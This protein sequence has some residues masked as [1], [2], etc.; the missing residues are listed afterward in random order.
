MIVLTLEPGGT[1]RGVVRDPDGTP[2]AGAKVFVVPA[3]EPKFLANPRYVIGADGSMSWSSSDDG[4]MMGASSGSS[5]FTGTTK[6]AIR[7][8]TD[9]EGAYLVSGLRIPAAYRV[10][11]EGCGG[12]GAS[13]EVALSPET[14]VATAGV[15]LA[16]RAVL[17]VRLQAPDGRPATEDLGLSIVGAREHFLDPRGGRMHRVGFEEDGTGR[18][19]WLVAG[20]YEILV[21]MRDS[22]PQRKR[23]EV[24]A[25]GTTEVIVRGVAGQSLR[26]VV[27][28]GAGQPVGKAKVSLYVTEATGIE[29]QTAGGATGEDGQFLLTGLQDAPG[30][31]SVEAP[32]FVPA[33][34]EGLRPGGEPLRVVLLGGAVLR[35]RLA[36]RNGASLPG[37]VWIFESDGQ[38]VRGMRNAKIAADGSFAHPCPRVGETTTYVLLPRVGAPVV[39]GRFSLKAEEVRDLGTIDVDDGRVVRGRVVD[40]AGAGLPGVVV[41]VNPRDAPGMGDGMMVKAQDDTTDAEGRFTIRGVVKAPIVVTTMHASL[42]PARLVDPAPGDLTI[43]L[44]PGAFLS[45]RL[46]DATGAPRA[47]ARL[48]IDVT[49]PS[50]VSSFDAFTDEHGSFES[51]PLET[52]PFTAY[53]LGGG[54]S[55]PDEI[56]SGTLSDGER[57]TVEWRSR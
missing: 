27:V 25:R 55:A 4:D 29:E 15:A 3:D 5:T 47:D 28:D 30:A 22:V 34:L 10:M 13:A 56:A 41:T 17:V 36:I 16:P 49:V 43:T 1:L 33:S 46:L 50:G 31:L 57:K 44:H 18:I 11:A 39:L 51:G 32:G 19:E 20:T 24:P 35:G 45:G 42:A 54:A 40:R 14:R 37:D 6:R 23:V 48:R 26:G 8:Q 21:H 38:H 12:R 9:P 52:G 2:C 7:L 53:V